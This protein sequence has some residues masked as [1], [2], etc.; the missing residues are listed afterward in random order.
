M[1]AFNHRCGFDVV[2]TSYEVLRKDADW[3]SA[4]GHD[5]NYM[6]LDE[7]HVI[8][9]SATKL[10]RAIKQLRPRNRLLLTGTPVQNNVLELWSLFDFLMPGFLGDQKA[11]GAAYSKPV[12]AS[13]DP[14]AT[15]SVQERGQ[16]ALDRL[17]K[18]VPSATSSAFTS[19]A[20]YV[21]TATSSATTSSSTYFTSFPPPSFY[22]SQPNYSFSTPTPRYSRS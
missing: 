6:V 10:S 19:S 15:A 4:P 13:K 16:R 2:I 22:L 21:S 11:F 3:L 5:W 8:R 20:A 17:H 18:Q 14:K 12:S 1:L 7:G 9:N